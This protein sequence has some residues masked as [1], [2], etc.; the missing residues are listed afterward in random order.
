MR[1]SNIR[2][3]A[4]GS[5]SGSR[6]IAD[7]CWETSPRQA[8]ELTIETENASPMSEDQAGNALLTAAF[9]IAFHDR[10]QRLAIDAP[11]CPMLA[12]NFLTVLGWWNK[13]NPQP[14]LEMA[15]ETR[16]AHV[17]DAPRRAATAF[18]SG[19][20]DLFHMLHC[21]RKLHARGT[22]ASIEHAIVVHGFDFGRRKGNAEEA[23][24]AVVKGRVEEIAG[25]Q[26]IEVSTCRTNLR[27]LKHTPGY[28]FDR[29]FAAA[30]IAMG[31]AIVPGPGYLM[32]AG[33]HDIENL[34]PIG[35]NPAVDVQYSSQRVHV[36]HEGVRFSRLQ[37]IRELLEWPLAIDSLRVCARGGRSEYNCGTCEKCLRTRLELLAVGCLRSKAFGDTLF[38]A[39][40]LDEIDICND[41]Q[42]ACYR[43][44]A[45]VLADGPHRA[46]AG[47]INARIEAFL[48]TAIDLPGS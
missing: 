2:L 18:L 1:I 19:G 44:A 43:D 13:W 3:G 36:V 40:L 14:P 29:Y 32:L 42:A 28:W 15:I 17:P 41:Y 35:S 33:T 6:L 7:L 31:H 24:F 9:P 11:V 21:N 37:K 47:A 30:A 26:G 39:A 25:A 20:V 12:D 38:D 8:F 34:S 10:E 22:P 23:L 16:P 45:R 27:H 5:G 48:K 4:S 46:L